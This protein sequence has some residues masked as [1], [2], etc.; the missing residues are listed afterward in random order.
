MSHR[1]G[2]VAKEKAREEKRRAEARANGIILEKAKMKPKEKTHRDRG[3]G[4]PGV[5]KFKGGILRLS[6]KD[7][8]DIEG[9]K[10]TIGGR[11]GKT[12]G[13]GGKKGHRR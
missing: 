5:G 1:K 8:H 3:V 2:I 7:I 4:A 13:R 9:P 6:K 12:G 10:K 11:S